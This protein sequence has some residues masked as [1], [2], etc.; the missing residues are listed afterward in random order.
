MGMGLGIDFV[1]RVLCMV[2][3]WCCDTI[4]QTGALQ[5]EMQCI[6]IDKD[7]DVYESRRSVMGAFQNAKGE[8]ADERM[9]WSKSKYVRR[10]K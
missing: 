8:K 6:K 5:C 4:T 7:S 3:R 2:N 1:W 10:S 9:A